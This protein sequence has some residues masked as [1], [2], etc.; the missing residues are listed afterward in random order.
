MKQKRTLLF[1]FVVLAIAGFVIYST[2]KAP[3]EREPADPV[4]FI[5][6]E[7]GPIPQVIM[8]RDQTKLLV[9]GE[10]QPAMAFLYDKISGKQLLQYTMKTPIAIQ[11]MG[12][13]A[14]EK[15]LVAMHGSQATVWSLPTATEIRT[16]R[17]EERFLFVPSV[18]EFPALAATHKGTQLM[19]INAE[20]N[21][22]VMGIPF[23]PPYQE[24]LAIAPN[25]QYIMGKA[26]DEA[27]GYGV[28]DTHSGKGTAQIP[29]V[30]QT[31]QF[32]PDSQSLLTY[33]EGTE[34]SGPCPA[35]LK[36]S[37]FR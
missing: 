3:S 35:A 4:E 33:T 30:P 26:L 13:T 22:I 16:L 8:S 25:G 34:P 37:R 17:V 12:I 5:N 10:R 32:A 14:D 1:A 24:I 2:T 31:A 27:I 19:L 28:W 21:A 15:F 9:R 18:R 11:E 23:E 6:T 36:R 29:G 20:T 7:L